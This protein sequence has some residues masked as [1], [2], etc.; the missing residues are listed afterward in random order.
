MKLQ[1][2]PGD[3]FCTRNPMWLGRMIN[4]VDKAQAKD[5]EAQY[6]HAGIISTSEGETLE[7]LWTFTKSN[8]GAY[9]GQRVLIGRWVG[10]TPENYLKGYNEIEKDLGSIY[11]FWRLFFFIIPGGAKW[12][13]SKRFAVCSERTCQF[14]MA[15]GV[16]EIGTWCG[17]NPDDVADMIKKWDAFEI[18][19]EG[20]L[21]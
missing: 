13:A 1:L 9:K 3:V 11:P 19:F 5:N 14:L 20:E 6:S 4:A 2:K 10:M 8:I 17:Q 16:K 12:I 21:A 18:V 7:E 15:T